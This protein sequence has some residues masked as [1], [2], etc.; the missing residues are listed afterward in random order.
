MP[1]TKLGLMPGLILITLLVL[2][3]TANAV[4]VFGFSPEVS[5]WLLASYFWALAVI[6][7]SP[8]P[9]L[10]GGDGKRGVIRKLVAVLSLATMLHFFIVDAKLGQPIGILAIAPVLSVDLLRLLLSLKGVELWK[11]RQ[12]GGPR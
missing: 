6:E 5:V 8:W 1:A 11:P 10:G 7:L 12:G 4:A 3:L 9:Y 2:G